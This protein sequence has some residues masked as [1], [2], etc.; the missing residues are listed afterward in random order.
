[1]VQKEL[2]PCSGV[3]A[4]GLGMR[5]SDPAVAGP[6][7]RTCQEGAPRSTG[8]QGHPGVSSSIAKACAVPGASWVR[9]DRSCCHLGSGLSSW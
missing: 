8:Q 3:R 2:A 5:S 9:R 7:S 1:M 4:T 6:G